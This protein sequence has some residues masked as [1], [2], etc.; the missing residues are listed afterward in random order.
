M[1]S[2]GAPHVLPDDQRA[3]EAYS[4]V[5]TAPALTEPLEIVGQPRVVLHLATSVPVAT[6]V[7]RLCD[8]APDGAS[9]LVTKGVL[10]LTHRDSH[11]EPTP[12][13]PG[14][15][16]EI[17]LD[18]DATAWQ[19]ALGHRLR[20]S[21]AHADFPNVW[22]MPALAT[23]TVHHGPARPSR[24]LLPVVPPADDPLPAPTLAPLPDV[25]EPS[26]PAW[27]VV[28]DGGRGWTEVHIESQGTATIDGTWSQ[29]TRTEAVAAVNERDPAQAS[30]RGRQT[31]RYRWPGQT[32]ELQSR[33]QITSDAIS[34]HVQVHVSITV[35]GLPH[36]GRRWSH[37]YPRHLL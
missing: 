29:E 17:M 12:L 32:I 2:A 11:V 36:I 6:V 30:V 21:L 28:R 37:S 31:V 26:P 8:V 14:A 35:D 10:N 18:L 25:V 23:T 9:A 15:V 16:Y 5:F 19:F 1:F 33:G 13:V 22:P 24:L 3:E 4:A 7:A 34:F 27:R 20:L